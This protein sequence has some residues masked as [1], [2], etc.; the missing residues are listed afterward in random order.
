VSGSV[1]IGRG[2][3]LDRTCVV[4]TGG[5]TGGKAGALGPIPGLLEE[6]G[7]VNGE[8]NGLSCQVCAEVVHAPFF[9]P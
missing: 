9:Q 4:A 8:L 5:G 3:A 7:L 6:D 2:Q 1:A